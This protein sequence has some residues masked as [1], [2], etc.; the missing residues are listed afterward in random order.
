MVESDH[1][2]NENLFISFS[3]S[4]HGSLSLDIKIVCTQS[5]VRE[6]LFRQARAKL[7]DAF[8]RQSLTAVWLMEKTSG[9]SWRPLLRRVRNVTA[10]LLR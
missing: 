5:G 6:L 3:M 7:C 1:R 4:P 8:G 9:V 2:Y 10:F